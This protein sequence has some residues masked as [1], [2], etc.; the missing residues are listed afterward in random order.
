[1]VD[2]KVAYGLAAY[3]ECVI[4]GC[5]SIVVQYVGICSVR[6]QLGYTVC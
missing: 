6:E 4:E 1:M 2:E 3:D 5:V